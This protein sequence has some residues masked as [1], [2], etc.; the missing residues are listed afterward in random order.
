[1]RKSPHLTTGRGELRGRLRGKPEPRMANPIRNKNP[2]RPGRK[3]L[4][5]EM[6]HSD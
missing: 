2:Q 1:V 6:V 4:I 3:P 5:W